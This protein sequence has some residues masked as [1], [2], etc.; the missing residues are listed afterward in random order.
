MED[1]PITEAQI[2]ALFLESV[3]WGIYL[4]TF[5]LCIRSLLFDLNLER[6]RLSDLNW[7]MLIVTLSMCVFATLDVAVGLLHN[8]Q[9]FV[10]YNGP[11]GAAEEFSHI[12]D[13]VNIVK[14]V[15]VV[16]QTLLGDG[17]LIY[18]CWIIYLKSWPV[19]GCSILLWCGSAVCTGMI[20]HIVAT[21]HSN[22]LITSS[23]LNPLILSFWV[24]SITQNI[25]TTG[26]IVFRIW[27]VDR[28]SSSFAYHSNSS[29]AKAHQG[30]LRE[31]M[32]IILDA[33][34]MYATVA[35]LVFITQMTNSNSTYGV[36]DVEVQVVGITFNLII[37]RANRRA[38]DEAQAALPMHLIRRPTTG[39]DDG[40]VHI[41]VNVVTTVRSEH[42]SKLAS[43]E[44][45]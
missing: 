11:G 20:I 39:G 43:V 3:F 9:A 32:R 45:K 37:I 26:L 25:T 7:P 30:R 33:G 36:S 44:E 24:L 28:R 2:V 29:S 22:A 15:D 17:M 13:W 12:S 31:A 41:A 1:F 16:M 4:V 27:R 14:T 23:S 21:L 42:I 10:Q 40:S 38:L 19:V 34:L 35:A 18:R 6:R 5:F 8:I